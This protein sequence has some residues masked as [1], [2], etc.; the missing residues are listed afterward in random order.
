MDKRE[1]T[2]KVFEVVDL[3][4]ALSCINK[5]GYQL[6][7]KLA[8]ALQEQLKQA[9]ERQE[10]L[11]RERTAALERH[12]RDQEHLDRECAAAI[13]REQQER[14]AAFERERVR[15]GVNVSVNAKCHWTAKTANATQHLSACVVIC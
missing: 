9:C 2:K 4:K 13:Q 15:L 3:E 7:T 11:D 1:L 10:R 5:D 8:H 12:Q 6:A 14:A